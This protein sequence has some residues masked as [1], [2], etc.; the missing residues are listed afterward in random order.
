M[1]SKKYGWEIPKEDVANYFLEMTA[2]QHFNEGDF[3][4]CLLHEDN[5]DFIDFQEQ[6]FRKKVE[7]IRK[8]LEIKKLTKEEKEK[9]TKQLQFNVD[10]LASYRS[11]WLRKAM[12]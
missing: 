3:I 6:Q 8:K 12:N 1:I 7:S 2:G 10:A 9:L 11:L 5:L 4:D